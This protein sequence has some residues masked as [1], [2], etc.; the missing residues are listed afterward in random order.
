MMKDVFSVAAMVGFALSLPI[1][2]A[3]CCAWGAEP[4]PSGKPEVSE[5]DRLRD[6]FIRD[7]P[8]IGL[9]TAPGDAKFLELIV[10]ISGAKSGVEV[11]A[12]TG[13]GAIHMGRAFERNGGKLVTIDID[14]EMVKATRENLAK[15]RLHETVEV[16]EGDALE[17]LPK[18]EGQYDFVFIDAVKRDYLKYFRTIEPRLR[19]GAVIVADNVI[20]S[21]DAMRDFFEAIE[22]DPRYEMTTLRTSE[23]KGDGMALIRKRR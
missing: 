16:I 12:A 10:E 23:L 19:P 8:R 1:L 5:I 15:V 20:R 9:N 17:V 21:A 4:E 11:G 3:A 7:F 2:G 14:P 22:Q 6:E 13:Y 18:L